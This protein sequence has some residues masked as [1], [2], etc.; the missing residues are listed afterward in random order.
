MLAGLI[1]DDER[2]VLEGVPGL[3][4]MPMVCHLFANNHKEVQQT[5]IILT[6]TPHIVRV[7]DLTEADLKPFRLGRDA[8][9]PALEPAGPSTT[10][11]E[12]LLPAGAQPGTL[13][14]GAQPSNPTSAPAT[15]PP[16]PFPQPLQGPM[17]GTPLPITLPTPPKK[18]GGG[19]SE[20]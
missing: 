2:T 7:L 19:G 20:S 5:D 17:P 6:L 4:D 3:S 10:P 1:R 13:P 14:P 15:P 18:P 12:E 9:T 8:G 11:R 16:T